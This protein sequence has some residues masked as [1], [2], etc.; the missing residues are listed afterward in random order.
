MMPIASGSDSG[1]SL[2]IPA[3]FCGVVSHRGTP[4]L[5][6]TEKHAH[7]FTVNGVQGPMARSVDDM[8]LMLSVMA[9]YD[10]IIDPMSYSFPDDEFASVEE[11]DLSSLR[12]AYSEDL[13]A[14]D[15]DNGIR[16]MRLNR[17]SPMCVSAIGH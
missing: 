11:V 12:I 4:G 15:V 14:T 6:P 8:R 2:R 13:G 1:G 3:A 10:P 5:V 17:T 9:R 16:E 7:G